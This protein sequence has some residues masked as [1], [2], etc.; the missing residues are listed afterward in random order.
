MDISKELAMDLLT[1][2]E[3]GKHVT[4]SACRLKDEDCDHNLESCAEALRHALEGVEQNDNV[5][6]ETAKNQEAMLPE[7]DKATKYITITVAEYH[8]LTKAATLLEAILNCQS[9]HYDGL[10]AAVRKILQAMQ[11]TAEAGAAE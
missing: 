10:V 4:C 9:Y 2:L 6:Q 11:P 7:P 3:C 5:S 8:C 1:H